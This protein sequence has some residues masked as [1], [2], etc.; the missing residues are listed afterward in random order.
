MAS[1]VDDADHMTNP[2][3]PFV[4][5]HVMVRTPREEKYFHVPASTFAEAVEY[6]G[7]LLSQSG[8]DVQAL[9]IEVAR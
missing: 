8:F 7:R 5:Y 1:N 2:Y 6:V 3:L 9:K 4:I